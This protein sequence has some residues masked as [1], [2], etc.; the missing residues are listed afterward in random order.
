VIEKSRNTDLYLVPATN[1]C[2]EDELV[3]EYVGMTMQKLCQDKRRP[4]DLRPSQQW[5]QN[6]PSTDTSFS[7][8]RCFYC[9]TL[10]SVSTPIWNARMIVRVPSQGLKCQISSQQSSVRVRESGSMSDRKLSGHT[11]V[12]WGG[13]HLALFCKTSTTILIILRYFF[14]CEWFH[15]FGLHDFWII[16]RKLIRFC[17]VWYRV[18]E[19]ISVWWRPG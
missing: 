17:I 12:K 3:D 2:D 1:E 11:R 15:K 13:K 5:L 18:L 19:I 16:P 8:T 6:R 9:W 10:S 14:Y 4:Y 7:Q